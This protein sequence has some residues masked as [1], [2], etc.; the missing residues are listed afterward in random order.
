[1]RHT[2]TV[3]PAVALAKVGGLLLLAVGPLTAQVT[4]VN[5]IKL[6]APST[7]VSRLLVT[8]AGGA[9][10]WSSAQ[11]FLSAGTGVSI[12]GNTV[13]NTLPDQTVVLSPG[14]IVT[15]SGS[16]PNFALGG[17][18]ATSGFLQGNGTSGFAVRFISG[19]T[20]GQVPTWNAG[21]S[22]WELG[23]GGLTGSGASP[24]VAYFG[25]TNTLTGSTALTYSGNNLLVGLA[26]A[27]H[28]EIMPGTSE[29]SFFD[30]G[31][32]DARI[33]AN[34]NTLQ[35]NVGMAIGGNSSVTGNLDVSG[36]ITTSS[37]F[38]APGIS[39][40][41]SGLGPTASGTLQAWAPTGTS[42]YLTFSE[43]GIANRGAF[44]FPAG[45]GDFV[46]SVGNQTLAGGT[47]RMRLTSAGRLSVGNT[48]GNP[49]ASVHIAEGSVTAWEPL[50]AAG[51][52]SG[53]MVTSLLNAYNTGGN[54]GQIL[55]LSVGGPNAAD[56]VLQWSVNGVGTWS[57][58]VSNS[59]SDRFELAYQAAPNQGGFGMT[60]L[61]NGRVGINNNAPDLDLTVGGV[62]GIE[63][64][65]GT[66]AHRPS[67]SAYILRNNVTVKGAE[68]KYETTW[69]RMFSKAVPTATVQSPAGTG[70]SISI[71]GN[72][73]CG[74]ITV[75][76]GTST[77][78]GVFATVTFNQAHDPSLF[79]WVQ[80]TPSND[81]AV[82]DFARW[83]LNSAGNTS[84]NMRAITAL[85]A[86][87]SYT[88]NYSVRQ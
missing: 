59:N 23:S 47:E 54:G 30:V 29:I 1:M 12:S 11:A 69:H 63:L 13:T 79:T 5:P 88:F 18:V 56:P 3:L 70:A 65:S 64:P 40:G 44:G 27:D 52:V 34:T 67:V 76:T 41:P 85:T 50:R 58:G 51:T 2:L 61:T 39:S 53:N 32:V 6:V 83:R 72:D 7:T 62:L 55:Q 46:W 74:Q 20:N 43:N 26:G 17:T 22:A 9:V 16:Y 68:F 87:T 60:L 36:S 81:Q 38:R 21:T 82:A 42:P 49:L 24:Q 75:N 8:D 71:T 77:T 84:F 35:T 25:G 48:G 10:A 78:T 4:K 66:T 86:S 37:H 80:I 45:S 73:L 33:K 14:G 28:V 15:V 31:N 19:T 57:A